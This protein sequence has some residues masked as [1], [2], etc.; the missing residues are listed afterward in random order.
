MS[1]KRNPFTTLLVDAVRMGLT[2]ILVD[3]VVRRR[4]K[5]YHYKQSLIHRM[6]TRIKSVTL[7]AVEELRKQN[8]ALN[9]LKAFVKEIKVFEKAGKIS[10]QEAEE[11]LNKANAIIRALK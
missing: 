1:E 7:D 4:I 3:W 8:A 9:I 11:V 5:A 6:G 2:L 10:A